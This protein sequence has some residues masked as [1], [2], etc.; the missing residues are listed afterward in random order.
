VTHTHSLPCLLHLLMT[1]N[2]SKL[3]SSVS[4]ASFNAR[5]LPIDDVWRLINQH[6]L[7]AIIQSRRLTP[8]GHIMHMDDNADA[9][10]IL[11][12]SPPVDWRRQ[13]GHPH[14]TWLSTVQQDLKH[15]LML[16]EA[17][18]LVQNHPLW[19]MMSI[20]GTTHLRVACQK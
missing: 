18:D 4:S 20:Y 8:F 10:R 15:H 7:T 5:L 13:P 12:A 2:N 3:H 6:K 19:R 17:A 9:K 16:P 1:N 11:L 14:I